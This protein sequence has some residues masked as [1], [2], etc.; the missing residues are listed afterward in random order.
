[1]GINTDLNVDPYYDDFSEA[2]QFNRILFKPAKAVQARELTQLQTILQK[3]VER[4]GSNVYKEGTIISG[5]NLTARDDLF[6]IKLNDL[7]GFTDPTVYDQTTSELGVTTTFTI[8]GSNSGLTAEIVKGQAGFQTQDPDLKTF[9]IK[10]LTTAQDGDTDIKQ[11][12]SGEPLV[13]TNSIGEK[14]LDVTAASVANHAGRS[15]GVSCEEGVVFQKGHFIFV[16]RQFII[17]SKYTNTPGSVSVGFTIKENLIAS[18]ADTTLLDNASGFN[19]EN[20][21]GADRLQLVPTLVSYTTATEPTEFF[22]LIRYVDG[23]PVR[24]R[25]NTEFNSINT[26]MARRTYDESGNYV[27]RGLNVTLEQSGASS[28]AVVSPGKAYVYGNEVINVSSKRMLINPTT[29]TQSK[30]NQYTGVSYGQYYT[31]THTTGQPLNYFAIDGTRYNI[32]NGSTN[33]GT[34]S[35]ANVAPGKIYVYAITRGANYKNTA[36]THIEGTELANSGKLF[37]V[38][39]N[40]KIFDAGKSSMSSISSVAVTQRIRQSISSTTSSLT[41]A[42]TGTHQPLTSNVFAVDSSNNLV[43]ASATVTGGTV[44]VAFGAEV[45]ADPSTPAFVYYD[46]IV[47]GI[48]QDALEELDVYV[49]AVYTGGKATIGLPNAIQI[50]EVKDDYGSLTSNDITSKFRLVSNQKDH[51]YDISHITLKAGED[52]ADTN[53]RMK[54]KVLRRTSTVGSGYLTVDS[55]TNVT[56]KELIKTYVG[57]NDVTNN[58]L[59]S[60][61]FRPYVT[62]VV[63]YSIGVA[64]APTA[65]TTSNTI[66]GGIQPSIDSS[67]S[68]THAYYM[69]RID[70]IVIDEFGDITMFKGGEAEN[71]SQPTISNLYAINHVYVPGNETKIKGNN[72]IRLQDVSNKNYTMKDIGQIAHRIDTLVDIVSFTLLESSTKDIF[73]PDSSGGNRFKNGILVDGFKNMAVGELSDPEFRASI[74]KTRTIAS[75]SVTQFPID[76]KVG[77]S[78]GATAYQDIVTLADVGADVITISQPFATNFRNCV[79]NFYAYNGKAALLPPFDAGYNVIT[80]PAVEF[81]IDFATPLLDLVDNIQELVPL[82][83]EVPTGQAISNGFSGSGRNRIENFTQDVTISTLNAQTSEFSTAVG[84]FVTD[85]NMKPFVQSREVKVLVTGLRPNTQHYFFFEETP[86]NTHVFPGSVNLET[87]SSGTEYN[88]SNV[89]INGSKGAAVRAD[90]EGTLS[91]VFKIPEDTFFVGESTLEVVDVDTYSSI[92]SAKTSYAKATYRAFNFDIGKSE[93]NFTTRTVDFDVTRNVVPRQFTRA[94]PTD[95]IAQ[96]FRV[97]TAQ[98]AGAS[99]ISLSEVDLYFKTKSSTLGVTVEIREVVNGY[100]SSTVLPFARKHLRANQVSTSST[101]LNATSFRF[102]NPVRLN[103]ESEYCFVVMPDA[104]SPDYLIWTSKVGST[105]VAS[106]VAITNDWGD[107]VLFTSTN[108][109]AWKSYQDEDIKFA[110]KRYDFQTSAGHV[111]LVPNDVEFLTVRGTTNKFQND[112]LA[113]IKKSV[114]YPV[115]ISGTTL[116]TL[117]I[118]GSTVFSANDYIHIVSG[119]NKFLSKITSVTTAVVNSVTVS[120]IVIDTPYNLGTTTSATGFTCVAGRVSYFNKRKTNRLFL[121][122]SSATPTNFIDDNAS[123]AHGS[124]IV[125]NTY[126][127]TNV[128]T[129]STTSH[130]NSAGATG[131]DPYLGQTFVATTVGTPGD[132]TAREND[133]VIVGYDSGAYATVTS[134]DNEEISYFQPQVYTSNSVRTSTALSLYNGTNIDKTI[135]SGGNVYL[136]NSARTVPSRSNIVDTT[137]PTTDS[138]V[139]KVDMSNNGYKTATPIVDADLSILNAYKYHITNTATTSSNWISREIVLQEQLDA[140][141]LKVFVS[142][143]RPAGT[144]VDTYVRFTY[145][146]NVEV[147]SDWILLDNADPEMYSN[148]SN[149]KDYRLFEYDLNETTYSDEFSSFQM[150]FVMR[151]ATSSEIVASDLVVTPAVNI[152]PH[153]YDYRAIALT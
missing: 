102:K 13:I 122:E 151:H 100:P 111:N 59:N 71:P 95:P 7:A 77:T 104:N 140:T 142:A 67:I 132:G 90:S 84:N 35:I 119:T 115:A 92:D 64:G 72:A 45:S 33:I 26:E 52:I 133:Q 103:V 51:F 97:K 32:K 27:T 62:P 18:G 99:T 30:T 105:D 125:G 93:L 126:T 69:S 147:Q 68:A 14:L 37:G 129:S 101:A 143:Y 12:Q 128:G 8:R 20:A 34:C 21:P 114:Q 31:Y 2:K 120:T 63:A 109:S 131:T 42:P 53:L 4:F 55:Y 135:D 11:F 86:V 116:Q 10:Y 149:T 39:T 152:F 24:I 110:I 127:I 113:Y 108:D 22:A 48:A 25:D 130:W 40:G 50:L 145:P 49:K 36:A 150:K 112:E 117:T 61:D 78:T 134:V 146:T 16:D 5:I 124:F 138:F 54:I 94:A 89:Q 19:N 76:L 123:T 23:S 3:Q 41:L 38:M 73:I 96:T 28:F 136:T 88:V 60:Y 6:Y 79:S 44:T 29:L 87:T 83:R 75:P 137:D 85:I 82:T 43:T 80:N 148:A 81:E 153:I 47:T 144:F 56:K 141:G 98:A 46:A 74:D 65:T 57:K 1:M 58:L 118:S 15:F 139:I 9:F 66:I 70:S 91:A 17:V 107:G 121:R 106:N